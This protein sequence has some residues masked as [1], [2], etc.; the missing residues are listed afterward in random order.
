MTKAKNTSPTSLLRAR[1]RIADRLPPFEELLRASLLERQV[2]CG[3]PTCHCAEGPGHPAVYVGV[4]FRG[5]C[6]EQITVPRPLLPTIRRWIRN[7]QRWWDAIEEVSAINRRL[8]RLR[9]IADGPSAN[10]PKTR[11]GPGRRRPLKDAGGERRS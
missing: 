7:Y 8:L 4:T 3:K 6:T 9:R 5:G 2:R 10:T 1:R 11:Q